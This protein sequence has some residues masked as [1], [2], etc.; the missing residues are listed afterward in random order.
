[1]LPKVSRITLAA[2]SIFTAA[3]TNGVATANWTLWL[4]PPNRC[5]KFSS[6][7][8]VGA[9]S[10][11]IDGSGPGEG[12]GGNAPPGGCI[13]GGCCEWSGIGKKI[14]LPPG[15][16]LIPKRGGGG[17][18]IASRREPPPGVVGGTAGAPGM[19]GPGVG[20]GPGPGEG[21]AGAFP[22]SHAT[23]R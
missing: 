8:S 5:S 6:E 1:M 15:G 9:G 22:P 21:T 11:G 7:R 19:P 23:W 10:N 18:R 16:G 14:P 3:S 20:N 12:N 17:L 4:V 2:S 13:T